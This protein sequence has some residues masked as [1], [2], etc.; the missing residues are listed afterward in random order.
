[1]VKINSDDYKTIAES[2]NSLIASTDKDRKVFSKTLLTIYTPVSSGLLFLSTTLSFKNNPEKAYFLIIVTSG[3]LIVISALIERFGY[4]LI[5]R[6]MTETYLAHVR[7]TGR[8]LD[9]PIG[10]KKWQ[11]TLVEAQIFIML[12]LLVINIGSVLLFVYERVLS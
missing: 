6:H 8:H 1:M 2:H 12:A 4:Y 11:S 9:K 3:V 10:G 7:K 5:S